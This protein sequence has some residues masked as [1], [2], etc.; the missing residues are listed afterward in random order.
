MCLLHG[1]YPDILPAFV[2]G[3]VEVLQHT[4]EPTSPPLY[5]NVTF[6]MKKLNSSL[7]Y[8]EWFCLT[9][10]KWWQ[11]IAGQ[12]ITSA[13]SL[14]GSA[15]QHCSGAA[16]LQT[17]SLQRHGA[18]CAGLPSPRCRHC[19]CWTAQLCE[20]ALG[21]VSGL[22]VELEVWLPVKVSWLRICEKQPHAVCLSRVLS[23][24]AVQSSFMRVTASVPANM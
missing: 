19:T 4:G 6:L 11:M 1:F 17:M 24:I 10:A 8:T 15:G 9:G 14:M 3:T 22:A 5:F 23:W 18:G 7:F 12:G 16:R 21:F 20:G 13:L 2:N